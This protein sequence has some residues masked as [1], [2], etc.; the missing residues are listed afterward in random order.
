MDFVRQVD[1][2]HY[3]FSSY[4]K[5]E[6][7]ISLWHQVDEV[8][9]FKPGNVLEVGPGLGLL[10]LIATHIGINFETFDFDASL[11]P[12]FV[13]DATNMSFPDGAYDVVCAFQMLEHLPY[14]LSL[15]VFGE[16]VRVSRNGVVISVPDAKKVYRLH[17][18][19]PKLRGIN[20]F[21]CNPFS[22]N[23]PNYFDGEHYWEVNKEGHL[24]DKIIS[25][26]SS[27]ARLE[28]TYR[29]DENPYHRFFVFRKNAL[30]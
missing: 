20:F 7:W 10:K 11:Q 21:L 18:V 5:K 13:G 6:R 29:V 16:M 19:I 28:K 25:D 9:R 14:D 12:D 17:A 22:R 15:R 30:I 3:Q 8:A 24:L 4:M 26:F 1:K 23:I 2:E 27:L